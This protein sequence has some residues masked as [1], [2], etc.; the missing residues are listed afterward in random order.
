MDTVKEMVCSRCY[1]AFMLPAKTTWLT[2][3]RMPCPFCKSTDTTPMLKLQ[4]DG[5]KLESFTFKSPND[6]KET[7]ERLIEGA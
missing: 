4:V 7:R 2:G 5:R 1:R 3:E 6:I